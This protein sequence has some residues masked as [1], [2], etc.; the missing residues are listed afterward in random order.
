MFYFSSFLLISRETTKMTP[1]T[2]SLLHL[3]AKNK[4]LN[5]EKSRNKK[6]D[7]SLLR[8]T[9][10]GAQLNTGASAQEDKQL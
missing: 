4:M 10:A 5:Y 9:S 1:S 7:S 6:K 8:Q 3:A 2:Y